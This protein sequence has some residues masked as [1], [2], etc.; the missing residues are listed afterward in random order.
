MSDRTAPVAVVMITLNEA[1]NMEAVL[2]NLKGWAQEVFVVDSYSA[3]DTVDIALRHGAHVVQHAFTGF[4]DQWN[5]ALSAL[6]IRAAWTMKLDP[7][8]RISDS[9][10]GEIM[11]ATSCEGTDGFICPIRLMFMDRALPVRLHLMRIWRTGRA[12]FS[13]VLAN[14]HAHI[15][16]V[17]GTLRSNIEHH[18]SPDLHHWLQKQNNYTTAEAIAS[19]RRA[20]MADAPRVLGTRLQRRMWIKRNFM[21]VPFRYFGIFLYHY[22]ILGSWRVG[23][24]GYAWARLRSDV[25]RFWEYKLREIRITGRLPVKRP[26]GPGKPDP[27]IKQ[28]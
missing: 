8:E 1:H 9:L 16:G 11:E 7:D 27:R 4:G 17:V 10:K 20:P 2:K 18:D 6:P 25:Y 19:F 5:F 28:Y 3:D 24:V 13:D 15:D 12:I 21:K 22:I 26:Q 14:E 23:W